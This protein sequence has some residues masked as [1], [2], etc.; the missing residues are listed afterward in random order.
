VKPWVADLFYHH[1][2]IDE[3]IL[4]Q[5]PGKHEGIRGKWK[6][7]KELK[8]E[9]FDLAIL[10]QNAFE[11]ALIAF[12]AGIPLRGGYNTDARGVLLTHAVPVNGKVKKGHQ[13]DY[14]REMVKGLGFQSSE[15][16]PSLA[17]SKEQKEEAGR[18]LKGLGLQEEKRLVGFSP[19]A[20]YG[21]AKQ[22]FP[23]R[24]ASLAE[25]LSRDLRARILI[26]GSRG[27]KSVASLLIQGA[28]VPLMDL[29]GQTTLSQAIGLISRCRLFVT[30]DSGLMHVA[31]ALGIPVVAIFGSTDPMRTAPLG[32]NCR[33][34]RSLLPCA[35]CLRPHCPGERECMD[36]ITVDEVFD[37]TRKIWK[38]ER[39]PF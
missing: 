36:R 33:V 19:G 29:T 34:V 20:A 22:W 13:V 35:P 21:P 6:L 38:S 24:F 16:I 15:P 31:A 1:P 8:G 23:E 2:L 37:E 11:A 7:A 9:R 17:V 26:F 4:Y 25:R 12:L 30:N 32:K 18:F 3:V 14:Y 10:F 28:R 5:S 27:D 39:P